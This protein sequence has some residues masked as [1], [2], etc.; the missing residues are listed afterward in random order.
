[1]GDALITKDGEL[2]IPPTWL[3]ETDT[4]ADAQKRPR[5]WSSFRSSLC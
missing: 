3:P 4:V 2:I 5:P 1:M